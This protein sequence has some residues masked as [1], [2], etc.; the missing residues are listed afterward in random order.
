MKKKKKRLSTQVFYR[1]YR[2]R[3]VKKKS[4]EKRILYFYT[5]RKEE[6]AKKKH[7]ERK[8]EGNDSRRM[9]GWKVK[10]EWQMTSNRVFV[11][12]LM[13]TSLASKRLWQLLQ[14]QQQDRWWTTRF[15]IH[16]FCVWRGRGRATERG[17]C[18]LEG[19]RKRRCYMGE[20]FLALVFRFPV[21]IAF[22]ILLFH[23]V[24][25]FLRMERRTGRRWLKKLATFFLSLNQKVCG[26]CG[27]I[28]F[29]GEC[30][31]FFSFI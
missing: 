13:F 20:E 11:S 10:N 17:G 12:C 26:I 7:E 6:L 28:W 14:R 15:S 5:G 2:I 4:V 1:G 3:G 9:K 19:G 25:D 8:L 27:G 18:K 16:P 31:S 22:T 24:D 29:F 30:Y 23:I 21:A